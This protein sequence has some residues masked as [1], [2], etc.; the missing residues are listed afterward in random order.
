MANRMKCTI[1]ASVKT[2]ADQPVL[3]VMTLA[4]ALALALAPL[5]IVLIH[6]GVTRLV[7]VFLL[8]KLILLLH[9]SRIALP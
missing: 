7:T 9:F 4:L 5:L 3:L 8:P 6:Y 1:C 2:E